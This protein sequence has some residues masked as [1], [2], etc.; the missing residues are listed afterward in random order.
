MFSFSLLI[1]LLQGVSH[2]ILTL[3]K[4]LLEVDSAYTMSW[5]SVS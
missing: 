4:V 2:S 3:L 5:D 1:A